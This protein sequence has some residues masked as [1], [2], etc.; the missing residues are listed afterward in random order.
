MHV[1]RQPE[2]EPANELFQLYTQE[3]SQSPPG[4][5]GGREWFVSCPS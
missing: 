4:E 2:G 3:Y 5:G 1:C